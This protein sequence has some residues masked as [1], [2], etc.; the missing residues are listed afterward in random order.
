ML[1]KDADLSK[2]TGID[3]SKLCFADA[4]LSVSPKRVHVQ[5]WIISA[6][7]V[8]LELSAGA[9]LHDDVQEDR[10]SL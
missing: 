10:L 8:D 9:S 4:S 2:N 7:D 1:E 5:I 6:A 3:C